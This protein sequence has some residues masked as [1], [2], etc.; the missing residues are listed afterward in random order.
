MNAIHICA[1]AS[2]ALT[3][4]ALPQRGGGAVPP[5]PEQGTPEATP[6]VAR[7]A[8]PAAEDLAPQ[9]FKA[10]DY[11]ENGWISFAEAKAS[12]NLDRPAFAVFD[13]DRD[14]RITLAEF[15]QRHK[16]I[17]ARG[18]AFT[19]PAAKVDKR[20][21]PKRTP[22]ELIEAFDVDHDGTLDGVE[23]E[24]ALREYKAQGVDVTLVLATVDLDRSQHVEKE[25]AQALLDILVPPAAGAKRQKYATIEALFDQPE[26]RRV[27]QD[28]TP[29]P[30]R[31]LGPVS[32]FRRLDFDRSGGISVQDLEELQRPLLIPV[33]AGAV[34]ATLDLD[35]DGVLS[36]E[37]FKAA[38]R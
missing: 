3:V 11:D 34:I 9:Y 25:E 18:G 21:I 16:A 37:E 24:H 23:I 14:G 15:T 5:P 36:P 27:E 6:P 13:T 2:I 31:I 1:L 30:T 28:A 4:F 38:L 12:M 8:A 32:T 26:V 10:A 19:P 33:R 29:H 7:P 20:R 17:T 35:G 22:T